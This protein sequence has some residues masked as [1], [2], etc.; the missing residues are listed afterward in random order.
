MLGLVRQ[1]P[2]DSA[3]NLYR[4]HVAGR[5]RGVEAIAERSA[6]CAYTVTPDYGF[7]IDRHPDMARVTIVSACSGHGF[8]HSAAI[9]EAV[10]LM[11]MSGETPKVLQPFA[12]SA[13]H[14]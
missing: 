13:Q 10:A 4:D 5:I 8:K 11:A 7:I 2:E 6:T 1:V 12:L 14:P 3:G 9:G